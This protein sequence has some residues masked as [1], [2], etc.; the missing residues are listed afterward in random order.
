MDECNC[1]AADR[2]VS[3]WILSASMS[4]PLATS[5]RSMRRR[6]VASDSWTTTVR[7]PFQAHGGGDFVPLPYHHCPIMTGLRA[8]LVVTCSRS[9]HAHPPYRSTTRASGAPCSHTGP[10]AQVRLAIPGLLSLWRISRYVNQIAPICPRCSR[11]S[12]E[13][14]GG[15]ICPLRGTARRRGGPRASSPSLPPDPRHHPYM[16]TS[17]YTRILTI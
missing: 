17:P 13:R 2:P 4:Q 14:L 3:C 6:A 15:A 12:R 5:S 8:A 10:D 16:A 11:C 7:I 9:P 1:S